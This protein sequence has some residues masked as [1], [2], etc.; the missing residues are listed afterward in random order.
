MQYS[1]M[2]YG[3]N[4]KNNVEF[5]HF[6]FQA[7]YETDAFIESV[8][9]SSAPLHAQVIFDL[10]EISHKDRPQFAQDPVEIKVAENAR[11]GNTVHQIS[12]IKGAE[13]QHT[14]RY[15]T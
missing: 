8:S 3:E 12:P 6:F 15:F 10:T 5:S 9:G 13:N 7:T 2:V 1:G 14:V 4:C 11:L